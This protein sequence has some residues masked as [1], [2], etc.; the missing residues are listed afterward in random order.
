MT[1][2]KRR[3]WAEHVERWRRS[4]QSAREYASREGLNAATLYGWSSRLGRTEGAAAHF[5]EVTPAAEPCHLELH[6]GQGVTVKVE[7]G[8]DRQL[9]REV[10]AALR[11]S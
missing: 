11:S 3:S 6:L 7:P 1:N 8:F 10:V 4:G 5:I 2:K 9:L